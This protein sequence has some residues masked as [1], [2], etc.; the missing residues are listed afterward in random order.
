MKRQAD[1][2]EEFLNAFV[3]DQLELPE[4]SRVFGAIDADPE[5][6][7]RVCEQHRLKEMVQHAY[8]DVPVRRV[9]VGKDGRRVGLQALA[10]ALVLSVGVASGWLA[11]GWTGQG[12]GGPLRSARLGGE[13][14]AQRKVILHV[15][16]SQPEKLKAAL[17]E[18][19]SLLSAY[20]HSNRELRLEVIANSGGLKLLQANASP[21]AERI[22][23][24]R[25]QYPNL[26]FLACRQSIEKMREK[27]VRVELLPG[28]MEA[29]SAF[30]QVV[31]RLR[32][33]WDYIKV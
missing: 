12:E 22:D 29:P 31:L 17:D 7:R 5:L 33:G 20:R 6:N 9:P 21:Y 3:D 8:R 26:T 1:V 23:E 24:L 25:R 15:S 14:V 27:G 28:V 18:T 10:A 16:S 19:E 32:Q 13:V 30:D 2:S 11:H 4:Q